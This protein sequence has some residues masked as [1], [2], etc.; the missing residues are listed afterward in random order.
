MKNTKPGWK[1]RKK[2]GSEEEQKRVSELSAKLKL[3]EVELEKAR[4][5]KESSANL[6]TERA[7]MEQRKEDIEKQR[8]ILK[9]ELAELKSKK[10]EAQKKDPCV[11]C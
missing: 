8:A 5:S 9:K 6:E 3:Y 1:K 2:F 4:Q 10:L 11:I 7:K